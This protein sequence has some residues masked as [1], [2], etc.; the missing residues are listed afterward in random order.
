MRLF[1][2]IV[3]LLF[4]ANPSLHSADLARY[5]PIL[6]QAD[7][8]FVGPKSPARLSA[9]VAVHQATLD[10]GNP[11]RADDG[12]QAWWFGQLR[13]RIKSGLD[14]EIAYFLET[15]LCFAPEPK[16]PAVMQTSASVTQVP[17]QAGQGTMAS[18][19]DTARSLD[20]GE[21]PRLSVDQ[22]RAMARDTNFKAD[23]SDRALILLRR[24]NPAMAAPLLWE[25]LQSAKKR[26]EVM[27]WEE[28]LMRLPV[29]SIGKVA[30]DEKWSPPVKAAWLRIAAARSQLPVT[31]PNRAGWLELLKGPANENTEAAW[32]AVPRVFKASDRADLEAI[33]KTLPERLAPRAKLA[34][35][36]V[37]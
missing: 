32:D 18:L 26:S 29:K 28:Q 7:A 27:S 34:I 31:V 25:R 36:L 22:L 37:R 17:Y 20:L 35:G 8:A 19:A 5:E 14:P 11:A 2:A 1:I 15:E 30:Y 16:K 13:Q 33:A 24:M 12:T 21:R 9:M 6:K 23:E 10:L 4:I 3:A